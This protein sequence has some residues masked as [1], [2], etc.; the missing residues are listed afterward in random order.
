[1]GVVHETDNAGV[2]TSAT[3]ATPVTIGIPSRRVFYGM[4]AVVIVLAL[5]FAITH[6]L[7]LRG[8]GG[9]F[10]FRQLFN[11]DGEANLPAWYSSVL[12]LCASLLLAVIALAKTRMKDAF[13]WYWWGLA[14][15]FAWLSADEAAQLHEML[16]RPAHALPFEATGTLAFPWVVLALPLV[17]VVAIVYLRFLAALPAAT[18]N[19]FL[20]AAFLFLGGAAGVE[21]I[22]AELADA[23]GISSQ[24]DGWDSDGRF[25]LDYMALLIV[26]ETLE[27]IGVALFIR[28]LLE[29]IDTQFARLTIKI[30]D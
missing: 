10:G 24:P 19:L 15:G 22:Q 14:A 5:G 7:N 30:V 17:A 25:G 2:A 28:A 9:Q 4:L 20:L 8:Y 3:S 12:L 21:M 16:N 13:R 6:W 27:M 29:Y 11:M 18:R 1:M 23:Q 26:E